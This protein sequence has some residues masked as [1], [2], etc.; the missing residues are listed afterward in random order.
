MATIAG[1]GTGTIYKT[2]EGRFRGSYDAGFLPSGARRRVTASGK[3]EAIV[4]KRLRDKIKALEKGEEVAGRT[5]VRAW[6]D[7]YLAIRVHDLRP[8]AYR[9]AESPIRKW[10]IPTIGHKR[11]DQLT[12]ADIRAVDNAQRRESV[13]PHATRR[14]MVTMLNWAVQ[15]GHTVPPRVLKVPLA[16]APKSDR[17][18]MSV[19]EGVRLLDQASRLDHGTRWLCTILYGF[20]LGEALGLT[21]DAVDFD[22]EEIRIEWQLQALPYQERY[23]RASGFRVPDDLVARHLVDSFHLVQPKTGSGFR[24]APMPS[25]VREPL[26]RWR[27]LAPPNPWGLV[28]PNVHGRPANDHDDREE[29]W[30]LQATAEVG[31]P[32]GRPYHV[33][34]CRHFAATMLL[35]T[36]VD[37]FYVKALLGHSSIKTSQGYMH[38]RRAPLREAVERVGE[39]LA[40]G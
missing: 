6:A 27:D 1:Y 13:Q 28:W 2:A 5:T 19:E 12:P 11:L 37:E 21:W 4:R 18:G 22:A 40:L 31:H 26:L 32:A 16:K 14:A 38:A 15:E 35:E 20:R 36:G 9:A 39:R 30:A 23:N 8:K 10:V 34:E 33:H 7:A 3:S 24:V 17:R 25:Y 29:W